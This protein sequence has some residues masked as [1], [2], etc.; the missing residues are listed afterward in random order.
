MPTLREEIARLLWFA[1][2]ERLS[3][4]HLPTIDITDELKIDGF[5]PTVSQI[6]SLLRGRIRGMENPYAF[7]NGGAIPKWENQHQD[8]EVCRKEVLELL[9]D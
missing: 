3:K 4:L 8:Y 5:I 1:D 2:E 9:K 7:M 6:F